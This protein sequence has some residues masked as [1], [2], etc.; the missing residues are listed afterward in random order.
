M[1][2]PH[3]L[4][5]VSYVIFRR[6]NSVL[7]Q[8]RQGTGYMDGHWSTA[9]AGHVEPNESALNAARR[10]VQEELG[11]AVTATDLVPLTVMHRQQRPDGSGAGRVDFFFQCTAWSGKPQLMED[12]K[13]SDLAWF[14]LDDLPSPFVPHEHQVFASLRSGLPAIISYG[15]APE[16]SAPAT[17]P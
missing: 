6:E 5:P 8:R 1:N 3:H 10:E 13:A 14:R 11:I 12:H 16:N 17:G 4:T 15:F 9:A 2:S 7:L